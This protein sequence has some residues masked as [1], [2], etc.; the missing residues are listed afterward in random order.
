M[1]IALP[2]HHFLPRY[3]SG[4]ELYTYRLARWLMQHGHQVDVICLETVT[5]GRS[6][7]IE[8]VLDR[9]G[10]I[11]VWRL[12]VDLL[13]SAHLRG[14]YAHPLL[15]E[16]FR[17]YLE[18]ARPDLAHFQAGYLIGVAPLEAASRAGVP[19]V[20]TLHDYWFLCPRITLLRGDGSLCTAI[21]DDPAGCAWCM[22]LESRRYRLPDRATHGLFGRFAGRFGLN[23]DRKVYADRRARLLSALKLPDAVIAP[24]R[25]MADQFA[26]HVDLDKL[27]R[28]DLGL[29]LT[30][31]EHRRQSTSAR[32]GLRFGFIGQMVHHKGVHLLIDAFRR[33]KPNGCPIELHLYGGLEAHPAYVHRLRVMAG[34]NPYVYFHGRIHNDAVANVLAELDVAV[35]PS[36]WYENSPLA[37][38]EAHAA[39]LPVI[40]AAL[41]GM[42]ERVR[43][44]VDGL[45]F[46]ANDSDDLARK[47]QRLIDE[48]DLLS[49]L[50]AGV[51]MPLGIDEEMEHL[52][53]L[54]Q[55]L[56]DRKHLT[57]KSAL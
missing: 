33:L 38:L 23:G 25:F 53:R 31:F 30:P 49:H 35:V 52:T 41:G 3:S 42:T 45:H 22:R 50:R 29:D 40:S 51:A 15:G 14:R 13:T 32:A 2:I 8:A 47:M 11:P 24:S 28:I 37:L 56:I 26:S 34:A 1:K 46:R 39:G 44:G 7:R 9:H 54:Y 36:I 55:R 6:D 48:P 20:L 17:D 21:P 5:G 16:W 4:A 12:S 57:A 43:D 18:R 27:H 10:S 19:T